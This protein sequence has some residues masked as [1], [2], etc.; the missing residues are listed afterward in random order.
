[1]KNKAVQF[2]LILSILLWI[3][4]IQVFGQLQSPESFLGFEAGERFVRPYEIHN[5]FVHV[6]EESDLVELKYYGTSW[7][8]RALFAVFVSSEE[9]ISSLE[10]IRLNN[11]RRAGLESGVSGGAEATILW[12][13]YGIHGNEA[14]ASEAA[15][16]TLYELVSG[17][18]SQFGHTPEQIKHWLNETVI[19]MDPMLNPDGR[20]RYVSWYE[21]TT[22][23]YPDLRPETREHVEP[24]PGG[25]GNHYYFDLNRDWLWLIQPESVYRSDFYYSWMP[26]VHADFHEMHT[27]D[28]FFPPSAEPFHPLVTDWQREFQTLMGKNHAAYFDHYREGYF[29]AEWFDLFYPGY[30][31]SWPTFNG[32]IGM[33]YEQMGH[34]R[35]GLGVLRENGDTLTLSGRIRNHHMAGM[36]TVETAAENK[37]RLIQEFQSFFADGPLKDQK[38]IMSYVVSGNNSP[39]KLAALKGYLD[40]Q[41]IEYYFAEENS[42]MTGLEYLT[43]KTASRR[44]EKGDLVISLDQPKSVLAHL[45]FEPSPTL[46]HPE[47]Y[48]IT[49]W[50]LPYAFGLQ[51]WRA[52]RLIPEASRLPV[53]GNARSDRGPADHYYAFVIP[54]Q[55][56]LDAAFLGALLESGLTVHHSEKAFMAEGASFPPGSLVVL[57]GR[58][59]HGKAN[60]GETVFRLAEKHGRMVYP[61]RS[62]YTESGPDLASPSIHYLKK[63]TVAV[64]AGSSVQST[65][66][67]EIWHFFDHKVDYPAALFELD[68]LERFPLKEY[69]VLVLPDGSYS[70]TST[71]DHL[72]EWVRDGG[73]LIAFPGAVRALANHDD[74]DI[75]LKVREDTSEVRQRRYEDRIRDNQ[76]DRL[77]GA[78]YRVVTDDSH[79]LAF[80][81]GSDYAVLRRGNMIS[82][83][84]K[85]GWNVGLVSGEEPRLAGWAGERIDKDQPGSL[86]FG[87]LS[88]GRGQ[89]ILFADNPLFRGFWR[90][91]ELLM[92]NAVFQT[93]MAR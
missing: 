79:P 87:T 69:D 31:D 6:A 54:W 19:I 73:R 2:L 26:H 45:L 32:A 65:S 84:L 27:N 91:G 58:N 15:M 17:E 23:R 92:S 44:T 93:G 56:V 75:H 49:A 46:T 52:D 7:Q 76:E 39:D 30:G 22:G 50:A 4:V 1:M 11:R 89:I 5:Y 74:V 59:R 78:I 81:M 77:G 66:L 63:P 9:N 33:T 18:T 8:D 82:E 61:L 13:S 83:P 55:D 35:A 80:G 48:D 86:A 21:Q 34:G 51:A 40:R 41:E 47:T 16:H 57:S 3:S 62:G 71:M 28:Y 10:T 14:S 72:L 68:R 60:A 24:W 90:N 38:R 53:E 42:R 12:M 37:N 88:L 64:A 36:S 25:R 29:S 20:S 70:D 85:E 67:G 43:G